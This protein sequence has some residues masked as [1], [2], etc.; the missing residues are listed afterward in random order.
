MKKEIELQDGGVNGLGKG[1]VNTNS[2]EF[3]E[4]QKAIVSKSKQ[5]S[6]SKLLENKLLSKRFRMETYLHSKDDSHSK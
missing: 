3:I 6:K 4:L 1:N 2:K 5:Q